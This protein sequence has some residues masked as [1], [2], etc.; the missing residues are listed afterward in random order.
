MSE[1]NKIDYDFVHGREGN[2]HSIY[3]PLLNSGQP[4]KNSG[5]TIGT[6]F[7]LK[8]KTED[9][10]RNMGIDENIIQMFKPY[11]GKKG[12]EAHKFIQDNPLTLDSYQIDHLNLKAKE[13]YTA[14]I[15]N[16]YNR[17]SGNNK[18]FYDLSASQQTSLYSVGFQYGNLSRAPKFLGHAV[19]NDWQGMH[20]ELNN[21]GDD[22]S[23]RRKA[24]ARLLF[25][26]HGATPDIQNIY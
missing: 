20:D 5:G 19:N 11:L 6:G 12:A 23:T 3:V 4:H 21:F 14:N 13:H 24:E 10:L 7:D 17:A 22:F 15:A 9:S 25:N 1:D 2:K 26:E 8:S 16:Q 18:N